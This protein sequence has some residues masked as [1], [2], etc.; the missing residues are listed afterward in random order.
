MAANKTKYEYIENKFKKL[1]SFA[2]S[3]FG[4]KHH[5]QEDGTQNYLVFQLISRY[6]KVIFSTEYVSSWK[7]K[8]LFD[9]T[10]M[11]PAT[12]DDSLTPALSYYAT[13]TRINFTGKCLKQEIFHTLMK[14]H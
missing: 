7:S 10:I 6:F 4:G 2:L 13:N 8:G 5:F 9:E 3:Y 11:Q 12:S 1:K 14:Q